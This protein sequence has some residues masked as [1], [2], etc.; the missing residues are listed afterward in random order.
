MRNEK[1]FH[2][3]GRNSLTKDGG[4]SEVRERL[5]GIPCKDEM[6]INREL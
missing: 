2:H 4:G 5:R 3:Y 1:V 6:R